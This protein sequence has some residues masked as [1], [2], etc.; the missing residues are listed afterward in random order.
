MRRF[1][2]LI[3]A[4]AQESR[5]PN[6]DFCGVSEGASPDA[7][8]FHADFCGGSESRPPNDEIFLSGGSGEPPSERAAL[9]RAAL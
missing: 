9:R 1:A 8:I 5:P 2:T 4:A 3:F 6:D 7:P